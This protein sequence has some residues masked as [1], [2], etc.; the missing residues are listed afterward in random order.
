MELRINNRKILAALAQVC[1]GADKM[2]DITVAIDKL[3]K[4]GL[5]KVKEEL[6]QRG[7][8]ENQVDLI[9]KYL[10]ISGNSEEKLSQAAAILGADEQGKK[11][12]E[13]LNYIL[14]YLQE[15]DGAYPLTIDFTLARGLN[16]YTGTIF[17]VKAPACRWAALAAV[18]GTTTSRVYLA[19]P[20][21]PEW[22]YLLALTVFM[23]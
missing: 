13:E 2:T 20:E 22:E 1:G 9:E 23:M 16:Y 8:D 12:L 14:D 7:L 19:F 11:G 4:I 10:S 6:R 15:A 3:D 18:E 21:F 17:E 5:E